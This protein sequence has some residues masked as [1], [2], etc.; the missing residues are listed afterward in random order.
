MGK[1]FGNDYHPDGS[2]RS[3]AR[4]RPRSDIEFGVI[5]CSILFSVNTAAVPSHSAGQVITDDTLATRASLLSRMRHLS[6]TESWRTF[7]DRY[8]RLIYNVALKSGLSDDAAQEIVQETVI[9]VARKVPEFHYDPARGSFKQWL[10]LITRRRIQDH[11]RRVYRSL[12]TVEAGQRPM[13][14]GAEELA[15]SLPA[16]DAH[17]DEAWEVEWRENLFQ[18]ALARVRQRV[19][20]KHYQVFDCSVLQDQTASQVARTLGLN[21]AQVYLIKHRM[22]LAVKRAVREL[23]A[24]LERSS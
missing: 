12:P 24:E 1:S 9:A 4:F 21:T 15:A 7:F 20:P 8:W 5:F 14:S 10:L 6:D 3:P 13:E 2:T 22:S 23:E 11:F 17:L 18:A 19:N 16:P